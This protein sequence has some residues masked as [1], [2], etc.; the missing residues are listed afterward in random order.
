MTKGFKWYP[1]K[2]AELAGAFMG[3]LT[4]TADDIARDADARQVVPHA[5]SASK[6]GHE[7]GR[8]ASSVEVIPAKSA[9]KGARIQWGAPF[10]A[11]AYFHPEWEFSKAVHGEA[12]GRWMDD[13]MQG[14]EREGWVHDAYRGNLGRTGA[15]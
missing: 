5:Q 13:Y 8:L 10:A 9:A 1:G 3:A 7:A 11:R 12:K 4:Q 14:G 6:P 2:R 15:I